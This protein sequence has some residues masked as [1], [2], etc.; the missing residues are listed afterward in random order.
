MAFRHYNHFGSP[1]IGPP[2]LVLPRLKCNKFNFPRRDDF[3]RPSHHFFRDQTITDSAQHPARYLL[4]YLDTAGY[5]SS[6]WTSLYCDLQQASCLNVERSFSHNVR[7]AQNSFNA[8]DTEDG[9]CASITH[10]S[11]R[12]AGS[13]MKISGMTTVMSISYYVHTYV[14]AYIRSHFKEI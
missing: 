11:A 13:Q 14:C 9:H 7:I 3:W 4:I 2:W 1:D 6:S 8:E 10:F 5:N 12:Q